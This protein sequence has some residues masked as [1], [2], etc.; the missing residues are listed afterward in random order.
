MV[1]GLLGMFFGTLIFG[2]AG[3]GAMFE[4]IGLA[5]LNIAKRIQEKKKKTNRIQGSYCV[6]CPRTM[7]HYNR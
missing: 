4:V 2:H 3:F 7:D 1:L 6:T 5:L